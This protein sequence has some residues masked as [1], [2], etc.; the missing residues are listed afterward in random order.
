[1][2]II[3]REA[4]QAQLAAYLQSGRPEFIAVYGRHRVGKTY[5]IKEFFN[6]GFSFYA[7]GVAGVSLKE[8]LRVF[9]NSLKEYGSPYK[10]APRDWL[11]AFARLKELLLAP[12]ARRDP[13]ADRL[14]VFL[15]EL[16]WMDTPRSDFKPALDW[17][18][19]SWASGREDMVLIV[20]GSAT[21]WILE[22]L[23]SSTG[24]FYNRITR[25][26]HLMPFTLRECEELYRHNGVVLTRRQVME[27]Y[28]VFG[29]IPYYMNCLDRRLSLAQ[30][31]DR[32]CFQEG[33]QLRHEYER[34]YSSLFRHSEKHTAIIQALSGSR[35]GLTRMQL[36]ERK[37]I[38]GG[39]MLTRALAELEQCGFIQKYSQYSKKSQGGIY[40]IS[41]PFT[42]FHLRFMAED[43]RQS[44]LTYVG[45]PGYYAWCGNAFELVCLLHTEQIKAVL[46][47]RGVDSSQYAWRSRKTDPGAQIDLLID[48]RD[49]V[50]NV[51][52]IKF[53]VEPFRMDENYEKQLL[54]KVEAFRTETGSKKALHLTMI[55]AAGSDPAGSGAAVAALVT[56]DD[57]F[58][59]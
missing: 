18:W 50:V 5:L 19:N 4:E 58:R 3:G 13:A 28:M 16:P 22:N 21:S 56:G 52:E 20:C 34:L 43:R 53:T 30:N 39:E 48:R 7:T 9:H 42:L 6:Q 44:W 55:S 15:D 29:G 35:T 37:E 1:M 41:D 31:I 36:A 2:Q 11:E 49:D 33:G 26:M 40:R 27:S 45:T 38:G 54:H 10:N 12:G 57:L 32:L 24:G 46:G 8:Q 14:V 47:I 17:F 23:L 51:C 59:F 25:Q